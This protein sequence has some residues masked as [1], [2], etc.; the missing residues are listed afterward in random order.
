MMK[1]S[2]I[3]LEQY[4][5]ELS[6]AKPLYFISML[7]LVIFERNSASEKVRFFTRRE[8]VNGNETQC[9]LGKIG[10]LKVYKSVICTLRVV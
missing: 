4:E 6:T 7:N 3:V 1:S 8:K 10:M 2:N 9:T 5:P